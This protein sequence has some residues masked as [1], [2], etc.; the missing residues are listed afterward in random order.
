[1]ATVAQD[2]EDGS[3]TSYTS[4]LTLNGLQLTKHTYLP[5]GSE[6]TERFN[7]T[8]KALAEGDYSRVALSAAEDL[9]SAQ[10]EHQ[11]RKDERAMGLHR[12]NAAEANELIVK[13]QSLQPAPERPY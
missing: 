4:E 5:E 7:D 6:P 9:A 1:M 13:L 11:A 3:R 12:A 2:N 8:E 10:R